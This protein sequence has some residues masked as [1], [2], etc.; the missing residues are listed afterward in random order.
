[1]Q[2]SQIFRVQLIWNIVFNVRHVSS[3]TS[4]QNVDS[5]IHIKSF[6]NTLKV[7]LCSVHLLI[8]MSIS[9]NDSVVQYLLIN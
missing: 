9:C 8:T 5:L 2:L 4:R 1:M 7:T 6:I 3:T